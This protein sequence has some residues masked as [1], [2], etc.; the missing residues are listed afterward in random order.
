MR[1]FLTPFLFQSK[2]RFPSAI[3]KDLLNTW[4]SPVIGTKGLELYILFIGTC[5]Y[6][7]FSYLMM[8]NNKIFSLFTNRFFQIALFIPITI[9][10]T[11]EKKVGTEWKTA[12]GGKDLDFEIKKQGA[13]RSALC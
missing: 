3:D 7:L 13:I 8:V 5:V 4:V 1:P 10:I 9:K 2:F 12:S 6:L 11:A